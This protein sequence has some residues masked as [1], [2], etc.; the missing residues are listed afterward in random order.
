MP[1]RLPAR[2][3]ASQTANQPGLPASQTATEPYQIARQPDCQPARL[4]GDWWLLA[5]QTASQTHPPCTPLRPPL[6]QGDPAPAK[7]AQRNPWDD[8]RR[9]WLTTNLFCQQPVPL[10]ATAH[11]CL[12]LRFV[13]FFVVLLCVLLFFVYFGG[14]LVLPILF[15]FFCGLLVFPIVFNVF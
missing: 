6:R 2:L 12:N 4:P 3:P 7:K 14:F 10:Q 13:W 15:V 11:H 1:A 9:H 5:S 8:K